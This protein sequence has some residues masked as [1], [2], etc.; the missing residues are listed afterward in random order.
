MQSSFVFYCYQHSIDFIFTF[1]EAA[2]YR[3]SNLDPH[4]LHILVNYW[5]AWFAL[6][7]SFM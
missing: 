3:N 2:T 6:L 4:L 7:P 1:A 5:E